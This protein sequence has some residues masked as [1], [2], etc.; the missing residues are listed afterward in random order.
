MKTDATSGINGSTDMNLAYQAL[1]SRNA[2]RHSPKELKVDNPSISDTLET[3]DREGNGKNEFQSAARDAPPT[4]PLES[5][6][7]LD[8]TG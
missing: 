6:T 5:G 2:Q 4:A 1:R 3:T 7:Q 8:I